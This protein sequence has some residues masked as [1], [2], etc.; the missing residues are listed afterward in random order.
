MNSNQKNK[1][2]HRRGGEKKEGKKKEELGF[3]P[4]YSLAGYVGI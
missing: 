3:E 2:Y 4:S 1:E